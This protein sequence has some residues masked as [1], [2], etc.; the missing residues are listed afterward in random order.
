MSSPGFVV[1][2]SVEAPAQA[3]WDGLVD[4]ERQGEWV[5]GTR[6]RPLTQGGRGVGALVEAVTGIGPVGVRDVYRIE[7][8][9]PPRRCAVR[10]L[11]RPVRGP[12]AF[13]VVPEGPASSRI[14]WW[15]ALEPQFGP[16]GRR[17]WPAVERVLARG[18]RHSLRTFAR[19]VAVRH[20]PGATELGGAR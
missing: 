13:E 9:D 1:E 11:R 14:V 6:V 2:V 8:W 4:W 20:P 10:H 16:L 18:F 3:V 7:Q 12:A 15:E 5:M 19:Q 17:A